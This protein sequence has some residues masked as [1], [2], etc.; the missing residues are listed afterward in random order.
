MATIFSKFPTVTVF[1]AA[2]ALIAGSSTARSQELKVLMLGDVSFHKPSSLYR[3]IEEPLKKN[4]IELKYTENL[5]DI[6]SDNLKGF[7]GLLIFANIEHITPEAEKAL[8]DYVENWGHDV[9]IWGNVDFQKLLSRNSLGLSCTVN[10][11]VD[12]AK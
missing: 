10:H 2:I 11:S 8:L 3:T 4:G 1:V 6:N 9:R 12:Y 5:S 7:S